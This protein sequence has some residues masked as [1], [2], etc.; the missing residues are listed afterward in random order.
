[1]LAAYYYAE[2]RTIDVIGYG[3]SIGMG[4]KKQ[5]ERAAPGRTDREH[6]R[7]VMRGEGDGTPI[8]L[9]PEVVETI[10]SGDI[11]EGEKPY[12]P[13]P[14]NAPTIA[15]EAAPRAD[16]EADKAYLKKMNDVFDALQEANE[17]GGDN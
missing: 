6:L 14:E 7:A 15:G 17:R 12:I 1:M 9:T 16:I 2:E 8:R 10:F 3:V 5:K 11:T 4:G 13:P